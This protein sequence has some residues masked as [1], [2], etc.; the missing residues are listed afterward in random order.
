L[1][2]IVY[3]FLSDE[4]PF[5]THLESLQSLKKWGFNTSD[6]IRLCSSIDEVISYIHSIGKQRDHLPFDIDGAVIKVNDLRQQQLLGF[7]AKSPRWAI[8]YKF[9]AEQ[10]STTLLSVDFQVGRTG[11]VT[12]VANLKPVQ[13][14]GTVVKRAS[15]H[16]ADIIEKMDIR[17]GDVVFVEK[18]GE[19]IPKI[20][21]IDSSKRDLFSK[22]LTFIRKCPEC[23]A[24]LQRQ[25]GE[26]AYYCPNEDLCPPQIKGKLEHFISRKA[27]SIDSLGEGKVE[28]L[29]DN[30]LVKNVADLYSLTYEQLFGLEKVFKTDDNTKEK[31]LSLKEKSAVNILKGIESSRNV[32]FERVLY[33]IGI[34]YVGETVAKKLA[35]HYGSIDNL[36]TAD[37]ADLLTV[38]E[39]GEKIAGSIIEFFSKEKHLEL[40]S[41]LK[42]AGLQFIADRKGNSFLSE[43]LKGKVIVVSGIFTKSRDELKL[44]IEAHGG[45][46]A[47]SVSKNT[48]YLLGGDKMGP[49]KLKKAEQ[50]SIKVISEEEFMK[51]IQE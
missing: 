46:S 31:K 15:L 14:A 34:R 42:K 49:E 39:I 29:F 47:G 21:G 20:V 19:I 13:L 12:P 8:A 33:A 22:P 32:P 27:M 23:G 44:L 3:A 2:N 37:L 6:S 25:E 36:M 4:S 41:Q 28:M 17:I 35:R 50:L 48:D 16:N 51:I 9:K 30:G 45:K 38:E 40:I 26:A 24:E 18:G 7:T 5:I 43:K 1:E 10:V 11:A